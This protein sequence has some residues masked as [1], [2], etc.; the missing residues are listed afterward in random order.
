MYLRKQFYKEDLAASNNSA[1]TV[2]KSQ[3]VFNMIL[4]ALVIISFA[5]LSIENNLFCSSRSTFP[6]KTFIKI[7]APDV[8]LCC[9]GIKDHE[10]DI[11]PCRSIPLSGISKTDD[12]PSR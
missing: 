12:R 9:E 1:A 5:F 3:V 10:S 2:D 11:M 7:R 6:I 8:Q 4:F